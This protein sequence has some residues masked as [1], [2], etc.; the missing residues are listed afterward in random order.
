MER[1]I[2]LRSGDLYC[3]LLEIYSGI[4]KAAE[5][6]ALLHVNT[7]E[8]NNPFHFELTIRE[9]NQS[10]DHIIQILPEQDERRNKF[11]KF[12]ETKLINAADKFFKTD[13]Y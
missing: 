13:D 12:S 2:T 5:A 11:E 4:R 8:Q 10:V 1:F 9:L 3:E 7:M 6:A